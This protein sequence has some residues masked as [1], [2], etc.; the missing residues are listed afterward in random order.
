MRS[1]AAKRLDTA[2]FHRNRGG[3]RAAS[4]CSSAGN[5]AR[6][7]TC[8]CRALS[9]Q[10]ASLEPGGLAERWLM[11]ARP[12]PSGP[13]TSSTPASNAAGTQESPADP[14]L[15]DGGVDAKRFATNDLYPVEESNVLL[16]FRRTH[17][18]GCIEV[19]SLTP[20]GFVIELSDVAGNDYVAPMSASPC[21]CS[22][23]KD[24]VVEKSTRR[25]RGHRTPARRFEVVWS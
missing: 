19:K 6:G 18:F 12:K 15:L 2:E 25:L 11:S 4:P 3:S 20:D 17:T 5:L 9:H 7:D 22:G 1:R 16:F 8:E 23:C 10:L 24:L 14:K 21:T 13:L